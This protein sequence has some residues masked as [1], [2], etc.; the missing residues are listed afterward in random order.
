MAAIISKEEIL[1]T[2]QA[3]SKDERLQ[4][5]AEIATLPEPTEDGDPIQKSADPNFN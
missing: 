4:L 1:K 3:R 2:I 5:I